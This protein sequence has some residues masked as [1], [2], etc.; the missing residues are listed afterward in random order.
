MEQTKR[1]AC[2]S[3]WGITF[4]TFAI[5]GVLVIIASLPGGGDVTST[6]TSTAG[7]KIVRATCWC[8]EGFEDAAEV[9]LAVGRGDTRAVAGLLARGKAYQVDAGT[10]VLDTGVSDAGIAGAIVKSGLHAGR[11]CYI[12]ASALQ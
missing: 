10:T 5:V 8:A 6:S 4:L 1:A 3:G 9:W 12:A 2:G 7:E 11:R